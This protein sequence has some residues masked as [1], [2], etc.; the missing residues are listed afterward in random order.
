[1]VRR[2]SVDC[3]TTG[4]SR[5]KGH[6]VR[7][8]WP[9]REEGPPSVGTVAVSLSGLAEDR[10]TSRLLT[11]S[12]GV[13]GKT[14]AVPRHGA[15]DVVAVGVSAYGDAKRF[16]HG[17]GVRM[18]LQQVRDM[19]SASS[20]GDWHVIT[21]WGHG[22][23]PSYRDRFTGWTGSDGQKY[24]EV[25]SHGLHAVYEDD[26][27]L[28]ITCGM[29]LTDGR[30]KRKLAWA[31]KA[32]G[33]ELVTFDFA[34]VF[35][36]GTLVDRVITVSVD[37]ANAI[38]PVPL[39]GAEGESPTVSAYKRDVARTVHNFEHQSTGYESFDSY[40]ERAGIIVVG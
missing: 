26:V 20:R 19:V 13:E 2:V 5:V 27:A 3:L 39:S 29:E 32:F 21:C 24:I 30:D 35:Y 23:G 17:Q 1:M 7:G 34:D 22:S 14:C 12:C 4:V 31:E 9:G 37:S 6:R 16:N 28:A 25:Q 8:T 18:K 38:L 40:M 11:A 33:D 15:T 36:A 10:S